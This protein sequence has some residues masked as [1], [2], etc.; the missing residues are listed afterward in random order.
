M[1]RLSLLVL[2][3]LLVFKLSAQNDS[4][5]M[6][7]QFNMPEAWIYMDHVVQTNLFWRSQQDPLRAALQRLLDH[8][9]EHFDSTRTKLLKEDFSLVEVHVGDPVVTDSTELKWLNDSTFLVDPRGWSSDLYL[10]EEINLIYP[11]GIKQDLF[12]LPSDST[13]LSDTPAAIPDTLVLTIIDTSAIESL[14]I[15]MHS[16]RDNQI[17]PSLD[18][19][20]LTGVMTADR[21]RVNYY[22]PGI[23]WKASEESPFEIVE[24]E[25]QLDSLQLALSILLEFNSVRDSTLV[26]VNDLFGNKTPFWLSR[27]HGKAYRYWVKNYNNDSITLWIGNPGPNEIS[28]LLE[29][30]VSINRLMKEEIRH[31][32]EFLEI[33]ERSLIPMESLKAE[34]IY[35][36]FE[37]SSAF[38]LNQTYLTNWTKG[39]ESSFSTVLDLLGTSTYNN[40]EAKTQWINTLRLNFGTIRTKENGNRK[41]QDLIEINSKYNRNAWGKI[42]A[43]ASFYMKTQMANGYNY[44][45]DSVVISRFLNPATLTVGLGF[46]YKPIKNTSINI[47]PLSYKN[48]FV[49]DTAQI[50]QTIHGIEQGEM[51]KQELGA[52]IVINNKIS[53]YK[54]LTIENRLRLFSN[55]LNKPQNVDVDWELIMDQK[56]NWFFT[57][58]LNLHL[59]YDD[60]VRFPVFDSEGEPIQNPDGSDYTVAK[61]QF[62]EFI[63]L[64]LQFKF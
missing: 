17:T 42:G 59:I 1:K 34:P 62:R 49:L 15:V 29:D 52:Q 55:Y 18:K 13:E 21:S 4:L 20:G 63:G 28:L 27:G 25:Y 12:V 47:A 30:D 51:T 31:L 8:S 48:T 14:G 19:E 11:E 50:D 54:D 2:A 3:T 53:P 32:P 37:L 6:E 57:I 38:T 22:R 9:T 41:N 36:D 45:N 61:T 40:K 16:Y 7:A 64:S 44:P 58:R 39:G 10:D 56:I 5:S 60:D 23:T 35:W 33:P 46:E 26:L 24:S 43:S